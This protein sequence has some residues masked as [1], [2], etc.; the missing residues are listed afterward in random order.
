MVLWKDHVGFKTDQIGASTRQMNH[1]VQIPAHEARLLRVV[2]PEE[3]FEEK[4]GHCV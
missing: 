3:A 4:L 2:Q 1:R